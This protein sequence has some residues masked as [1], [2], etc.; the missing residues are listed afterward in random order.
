M[1]P[2]TMQGM[3]AETTLAICSLIFG[4]VFSEFPNIKICFAHGCG[5]FP[6]TIGRI[7]HGW[8]VRPDLCAVDCMQNPR[9]AIHV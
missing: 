9:S 1:W 5:A 6:Y 4:G 3:P 8:V 7:E 2:L